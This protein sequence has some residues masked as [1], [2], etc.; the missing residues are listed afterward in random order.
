MKWRKLGLIFCPDRIYPWM[1]THA[2]YAT[3]EHL[4]DDL[5]RIYFSTRDKVNRSSV[6]Y[7]EI[8]INEPSKILNISDKPI[9]SP[10]EIGTFDDSG[11]S[12][13]CLLRNG[14]QRFLY[15][16]GWNLSV[17]VPFR[18]S[19]GLAISQGT[20]EPFV[21]VSQAPIMDRNEIDPFS[22]SYP[23]VLREGNRWR[24]WYGSNLRTGPSEK[25]MRHVIKY[26]DS[27][28]GIH[29]NRKGVIAIPLFEDQGEYA[30]ARP[31]VLPSA[32][33]Y[34]MWYCHRGET[35]R[36]GYATSK[37][38]ILWTRHDDEAGLDPSPAGWDS[39]MINYP[40]VFDHRGKRYLLYSGNRFGLTGFGLAVLE[41]S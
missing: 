35:Y 28:D 22:I 25:D 27:P 31:C 36:L 30:L 3:P 16:I 41:P 8:N 9:I 20:Q 40:H 24:M 1:E 2:S 13:G 6:G 33:G 38:G 15:Y 10:G 18:N 12:L 39:E 34:E 32:Q 19:I 5:F 4:K 17:T 23:W 11:I 37:D 7:V 21:R 29:W 26:C 14:E